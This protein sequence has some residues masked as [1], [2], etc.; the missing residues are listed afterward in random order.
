MVFPG[1]ARPFTR[2]EVDVTPNARGQQQQDGS[3]QLQELRTHAAACSSSW[4]RE[5]PASRKRCTDFYMHL[6][7]STVMKVLAVQTWVRRDV[8]PGS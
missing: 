5:E 8:E 2:L 6:L 1:L 4:R 7:C 3:G